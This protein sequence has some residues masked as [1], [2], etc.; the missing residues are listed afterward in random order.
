MSANEHA[1][2]TKKRSLAE[3]L[4]ADGALLPYGLA[5]EGADEG[6]EGGARSHEEACDWHTRQGSETP[7][8][9]IRTGAVLL[10]FD[11]PREQ[12][13]VHVSDVLPTP[14]Q[15]LLPPHP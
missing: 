2:V 15:P 10:F 1:L 6:A 9:V 13:R 14:R 4:A 12:M 11:A 5:D 3:N 7:P 8:G